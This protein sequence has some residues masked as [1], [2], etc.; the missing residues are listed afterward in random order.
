MTTYRS[1]LDAR[2]SV[3]FGTRKTNSR[4]QIVDYICQRIFTGE[5]PPF[6][7]IPQDD[8]AAAVGFTKIP[9]REA[10]VSL[11]ARGFVAIE[12]HKGAF[13]RPFSSDELRCHFELRGYAGGMEARRAAER[14]SKELVRELQPLYRGLSRTD[15]A[16]EF[17]AFVDEFYAR[18]QSA[19][20]SPAMTAARDRFHEI[21][22]GNFFAIVPD[23]MKVCQRVFRDIFKAQRL[24]D[25]ELA[26]SAG[27]RASVALG[28][29]LISLFDARGQLYEDELAPD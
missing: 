26:M 14:G 21:V 12:A 27:V 13:V 20:G 4:E 28:E 1:P 2:R 10:L 19:G 6:S 9:V 22:P 8:V 17:V 11:E 15:D 23:S 5:Y 18:V 24:F 3:A 25:P 29:C 7:R 16:D